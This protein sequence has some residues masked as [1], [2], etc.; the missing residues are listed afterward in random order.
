MLSKKGPVIIASD[1]QLLWNSIDGEGG[2]SNSEVETY[3]E[4]HRD[5]MKKLI[6]GT[7]LPTGFTSQ[8]ALIMNGDLSEY[9][10]WDQW[11]AYNNIYDSVG[12]QIY[13]GIG[14]HDYANNSPSAGGSGVG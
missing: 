1:P 5:V 7:G 13:D 14:N 3:N 2:L 11:G 8:I 10:R 4:K 12:V 9:G 6:T